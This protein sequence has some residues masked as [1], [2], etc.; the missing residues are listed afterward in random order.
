MAS[1][2]SL[3]VDRA[4][5]SFKTLTSAVN[6]STSEWKANE[7]AAKR[8][9]DGQKAQQIKIEGLTKSINLQKAKLEDLK[10]QQA[11]VDTSTEKGTKR[12]YDLTNQITKTNAQI[13]KQSD[14]LSKAKSGMTY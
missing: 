7:A 5:K 14:Q 6:A 2:V 11:A 3:D 9:G 4:V 8:N 13:N 12:Y 10:K 1:Q